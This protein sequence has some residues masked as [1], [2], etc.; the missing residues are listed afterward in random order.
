MNVL[1]VSGED[2]T[3]KMHVEIE[4]LEPDITGYAGAFPKNEGQK[5]DKNEI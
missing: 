1:F 5:S 2:K 3:V 4:G